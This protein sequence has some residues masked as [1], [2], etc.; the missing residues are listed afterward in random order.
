MA[1]PM[2]NSSYNKGEDKMD[3]RKIK[4]IAALVGG[5]VGLLLLVSV[6]RE[7]VGTND[8]G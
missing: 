6:G 7:I 5:V 4:L 1:Y 2:K 8:A 3:M